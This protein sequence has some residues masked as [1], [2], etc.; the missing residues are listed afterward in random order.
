MRME[1]GEVRG[2]LSRGMVK[3]VFSL[4]DKAGGRGRQERGLPRCARPPGSLRLA[5]SA[6]LR[7]SC[8]HQ[9]LDAAQPPDKG[10]REMF[11]FPV[12]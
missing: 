9:I 11:P 1:H 8:P 3:W 7:F 10:A 2:A 12:S 6:A 4:G 5:I